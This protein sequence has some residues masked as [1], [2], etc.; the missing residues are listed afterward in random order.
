MSHIVVLGGGYGGLE[1][2]KQLIKKHTKQPFYITLVDRHP[3]HSLKTQHHALAAG[4]LSDEKTRM[5]FPKHE[6]LNVYYAEILR[7]D[8][9]QRCVVTDR[10]TVYYDYLIIALGAEDKW[11]SLKGAQTFTRSLQTI[12]QTRKTYEE[13]QN[14]KPYGT[15]KIIGG[16]LTGVE[17]ASELRESRKDLN[18]HILERGHSVLKHFSPMIQSYVNE[19]FNAHDIQVKQRSHLE[20]ISD[21]AIYNNGQREYADLIIWAAGIQPSHVV[22]KLQVEKD[23]FGRILINRQSRLISDKRVFVVGDCSSTPFFPSAQIA[24]QQG[25]IVG[26]SLLDELSHRAIKQKK[27][28]THKGTL[29]SLGRKV[30]FGAIGNRSLIGRVPKIMK[31]YVEYLHA[32]GH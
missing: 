23:R 6:C 29:G 14:T 17:L 27:G 28:L 15:I 10:E 21:H 1:A 7:V 4:T 16:G 26:N 2:I 32:K 5:K 13:I 24:K 30:G 8:L 12:E 31:N 22:S 3:F 18:I 11:Q 25:R 20:Y 19:W 9:K